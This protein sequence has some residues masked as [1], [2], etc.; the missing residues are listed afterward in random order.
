MI[1]MILKL[2][3]ELFKNATQM[4]LG[5][6]ESFAKQKW[7]FLKFIKQEFIFIKT[8]ERSSP[9]SNLNWSGNEPDME[10]YSVLYDLHD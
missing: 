4:K 1:L 7:Y 6:Y 2:I 9:M 5:L 10:M 8:L 3:N